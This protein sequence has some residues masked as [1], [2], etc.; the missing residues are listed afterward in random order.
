MISAWVQQKN[1]AIIVDAVSW[2][3]H[4]NCD[5]Y[6]AQSSGS[7]HLIVYHCDHMCG[8]NCI[9]TNVHCM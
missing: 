9:L 1:P 4:C 2:G 6:A 3:W 5:G 7:C 8:T